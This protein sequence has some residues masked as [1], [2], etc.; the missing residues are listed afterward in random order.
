SP[1]SVL[2]AE[3]TCEL[4]SGVFVCEDLAPQQL[5]GASDTVNAC[6]V[7]RRRTVE[8]RFKAMRPHGVARL[9]GRDQELQQLLA[10]WDRAKRGEGQ[11]GLVCGEAGIGKSHLC[12]FFQEHIVEPH[13]ILRYQCSP[14]HLNSPFYPV[15]SQLKH[16]MG[17]EHADTTT[18][19]F[20]K[21]EAALS[22]A[23]E[24]TKENTLLFA[25][26]LSIA[27]Q[28]EPSLGLTPQRQKDLIIAALIRYILS[29]ADKQPLFIVLAD[30]HWIDSS[31]LELVNRIIP[32][33]KKTRVLFLIKF[34]PDFKL[35]WPSEP[36]VTKLPLDRIGHEHSRAIIS[37]VIGDKA[38]SRA[39]EEEIICKADG[40]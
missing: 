27:P 1:N 35:Q 11:V 37:E 30:A 32:L 22:Q 18:V 38:L 25:A 5:T 16:A 9:I 29:H 26:L 7:A 19:K 8:S 36:H 12:E 24:P 39:L 2:I 40:I 13:A 31:T 10:L 20:E 15:I 4:L 21:L 14:H 34:R 17:F 28:R 33:I 6:R 23:L 3:S